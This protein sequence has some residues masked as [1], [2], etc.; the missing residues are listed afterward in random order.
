MSP[1]E[2]PIAVLKF[3]GTC[4]RSPDSRRVV[5][6]R[7]A[8]AIGAGWS[9]VVVVSA[10]GRR[11]QPYAT[12][13]LLDMVRQ[14][15]PGAADRELATAY[16]CGELLSAALIAGQLKT[17]GLATK[18]LSGW[19]AGI[20]TARGAADADVLEVRPQALLDMIGRGETPVVAGSQGQS[21]SGDV[22]TLGRGG[23]D[24]TASIL[25]VSLDARAIEVFTD[26]PGVMTAD[27][28]L[29]PEART[30]PL[31]SYQSCARLADLGAKVIHPKAVRIAACRPDIQLW[32]RSIDEPEGGSRVGGSGWRGLADTGVP[33]ALAVLR[34]WLRMGPGGAFLKW[35]AAE[36]G[37]SASSDLGF[38]CEGR[39]LRETRGQG[40]EIAAARLS[41]VHHG[42]VPEAATQT[43]LA[44]LARSG[45]QPLLWLR[46][47]EAASVFVSEPA[48]KE[49]AVALHAA[50][51]G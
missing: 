51:F 7:I 44:A 19:Q 21:L 3:G 29:V 40:E 16:A 39:W 26:T 1:A 2:K 35:R 20:M 34:G 5:G 33:V 43:Y 22:T 47:G 8:A 37:C 49:S 41:I 17:R 42:A 14:E 50:A 18:C 48:T 38:G 4:M 30:V 24:S 15:C 11:G 13:T 9:V 28:R 32:V 36:D 12:D 25:G 6:D 45:I 10:M 27:P 31:L 46:D 23:S